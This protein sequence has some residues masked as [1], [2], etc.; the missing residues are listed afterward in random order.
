MNKDDLIRAVAEKMQTTKVNAAQ[1]VDAI[2]DSITESLKKGDPVTFVGFGS[3]K[4]TKRA[5]RNGRNPRTGEPLSIPA[6]T[7][8]SF[9][10]GKG[11]RDA[12]NQ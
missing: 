10:A 11:L 8:P 7:V 4:T 5:A 1:A 6:T 12:V 3:F 2:F 9:T